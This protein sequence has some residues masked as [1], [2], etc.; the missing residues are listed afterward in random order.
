M[1]RQ[2]LCITFQVLDALQMAARCGTFVQGSNVVLSINSLL[3]SIL[4]ATLL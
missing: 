1:W 3:L 4:W 2:L